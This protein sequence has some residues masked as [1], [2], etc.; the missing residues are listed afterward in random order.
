[1]AESSSEMVV[2]ASY[3]VIAFIGLLCNILVLFSV[4][5]YKTLRKKQ[6]TILVSLA[7]CDLF[8]VV[9]IVNIVICHFVEDTNQLCERTSALGTSLL[10]I[11]TFHLAA[12]SINRVFM[13]YSPY[14]YLTKLKK[15][16]IISITVLLW[17]LPILIIII[18][19]LSFF[20]ENWRSY[21]YF[22][23]EMFGCNH[24]IK[25]LEKDDKYVIAVHII[26]LAAPMVIMIVSYGFMLRTS[27]SNAKN[28]RAVSLIIPENP[29]VKET[30]YSTS[31]INMV[32]TSYDTMLPSDS[33]RLPQIKHRSNTL[34][35]RASVE[36]KRIVNGRRM[37][38]KA[39]KTILIII[40][41]FIICNTPMFA[42]TW[43]EYKQ[44]VHSK[45]I[46]R[47]IFLSIAMCQI[48]IDPAIYFIRLKDFKRI[49]QKCTDYFCQAV[50]T[51]FR[52]D[53]KSVV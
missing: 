30:T 23:I 10:F 32:V 19:P 9:V 31:I 5:K 11:N 41:A 14:T 52:L 3:I 2:V 42:L 48:C 49:R 13:I 25:E 53:R 4:K 51:F 50:R 37:E 35:S 7:V 29:A 16:Y 43:Y 17:F 40:M 22:Q 27:C 24:S 45:H 36:L 38:I 34:A 21:M 33:Y 8:K 28:I 12:E 26:F 46:S 20:G 6:Y 44:K 1:M 18:F 47:R 15:S 39:A